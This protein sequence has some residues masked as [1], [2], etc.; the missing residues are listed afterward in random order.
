MQFGEL[1]DVTRCET[2][3]EFRAW[4]QGVFLVSESLAEYIGQL[5]PVCAFQRDSVNL[6]FDLVNAVKN[7]AE[8]C[9][10][11]LDERPELV[12]VEG[13]TDGE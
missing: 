2:A 12:T 13:G 8:Y 3:E 10:Q 11:I 7:D 6:L 9:V 1:R 5:L 4:L